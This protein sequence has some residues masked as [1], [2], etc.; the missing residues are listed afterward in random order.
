[1]SD[2]T[3]KEKKVIAEFEKNRAGTGKY[4]AQNI[5][6]PNTGWREIIADTLEEDLIASEGTSRNSFIYPRIQP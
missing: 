1:M 3:E 5:A 4:A 2:F 6:N